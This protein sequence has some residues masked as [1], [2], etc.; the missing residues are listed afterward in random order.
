VQGGDAVELRPGDLA[1]FPRGALSTW[2]I[3]E[4]LKKFFVISG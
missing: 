4:P 2:T 3:L 1:S